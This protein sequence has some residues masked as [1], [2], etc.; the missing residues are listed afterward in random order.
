VDSQHGDAFSA[1]Q[2]M[3]SPTE[4]TGPQIQQLIRASQITAE[5][6]RGVSRESDGSVSLEI[7]V[8]LHGVALLDLAL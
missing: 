4:P 1:W 7:S 5:S 2:A 8:P 6:V 3:G